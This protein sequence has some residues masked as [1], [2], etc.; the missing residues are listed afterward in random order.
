[1][2]CLTSTSP[3]RE[4]IQTFTAAKLPRLQDGLQTAVFLLDLLKEGL[5]RLRT[6][7]LGLGQFLQSVLAN[8]ALT[9]QTLEVIKA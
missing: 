8:I 7:W 1:L 4:S 9:K 6:Q 3:L 5:K 2:V